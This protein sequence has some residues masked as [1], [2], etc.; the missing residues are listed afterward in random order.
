MYSY[1]TSRVYTTECVDVFVH[2][3]LC[4]HQKSPSYIHNTPVFSKNTGVFSCVLMYIPKDTYFHTCRCLHQKSPSCIHNTPV[5]SKNTGVFGIHFSQNVS[6]CTSNYKYYIYGVHNFDY[7]Y[8]IYCVHKL[9]ILYILC[10][11]LCSTMTE[12]VGAFVNHA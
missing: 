10:T 11:Q 2:D 4:I 1:I 7:K 9:K 3:A 8:Y 6:M 12:Y 5:F